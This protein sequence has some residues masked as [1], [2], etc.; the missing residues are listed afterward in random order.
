MGRAA[1]MEGWDG[2]VEVIGGC[3]PYEQ[4]VAVVFSAVNYMARGRCGGCMVFRL[5][6][7][8]CSGGVAL[9]VLVGMR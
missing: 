8:G 4:L 9:N 6:P 3:V 1:A 7:D 5:L 2:C